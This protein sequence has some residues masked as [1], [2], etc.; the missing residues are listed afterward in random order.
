M[1]SLLG[2]TSFAND[3][4]PKRWNQAHLRTHFIAYILHRMTKNEQTPSSGNTP[5]EL[6]DSIFSPKTQN[7][8]FYSK[9]IGGTKLEESP[10]RMVR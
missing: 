7:I 9:F 5:R 4:I 6:P 1:H 2:T 3:E 8:Y 10:L